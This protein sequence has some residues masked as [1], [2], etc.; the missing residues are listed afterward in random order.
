MQETISSVLRTNENILR[1]HDATRKALRKVREKIPS[2]IEKY[3][4][5]VQIR[6]TLDEVDRSIEINVGQA[7]HFYPVTINS[8]GDIKYGIKKSI[9]KK[10][11]DGFKKMV[12]QLWKKRHGIFGV[13]LTIA[14]LFS[15]KPHNHSNN[16]Q[17]TLILVRF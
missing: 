15:K 5:N 4:C 2:K 17:C 1:D 14:S 9:L 13:G 7:E 12:K 11:G 16:N 8:N 6:I 10:F 3:H